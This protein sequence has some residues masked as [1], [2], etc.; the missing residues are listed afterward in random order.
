MTISVLFV[1][2]QGQ[3]ILEILL[4][5]IKELLSMKGGDIVCCVS[6]CLSVMQQLPTAEKD[7]ATYQCS[8]LGGQGG[9]P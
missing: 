6:I 8:A 2:F 5:T 7:V 3:I 4:P 1:T 9:M